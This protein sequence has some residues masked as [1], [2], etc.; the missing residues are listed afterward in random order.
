M[1]MSVDSTRFKVQVNA[2]KITSS[3]V[4]LDM[5]SGIVESLK[6]GVRNIQ[7]NNP[8]RKNAIS[9]ST[10]LKVAEI[11]NEDASNDEVVATI[12][13]GTGE[14]FTSGNDISGGLK[15]FDDLDAAIANS[16]SA[17]EAMAEALIQYPKLLVVLVNGPAIGVGV[18]MCGLCDLVYATEN[19]TFSTPFVKLGLTIE[20]GA[21]VLFPKI[22]GRTKANEML[23]FGKTFTAQEAFQANLVSRV[24]P[25]G[26]IGSF[27]EDLHK[28]IGKLNMVGFVNN[29]NLM[30]DSIQKDLLDTFYREGNY[31]R[32]ALKS[33]NFMNNMLLFMN[34]KSKL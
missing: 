21:S 3:N 33:E 17:Y 30:K 34:R 14:Y 27:V 28:K 16:V 29:K 10:Y 5:D 32:K 23:L 1:L 20:A 12:F 24:I 6:D 4:I 15:K 25:Q 18:T 26:D 19:A 9:T 8:K 13:T 31:L 22:M 7:F 2:I 11:L